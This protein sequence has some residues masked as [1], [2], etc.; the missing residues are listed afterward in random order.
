MTE[1]FDV[2]KKSVFYSHDQTN[3]FQVV[4]FGK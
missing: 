4:K 2:V 3:I 1:N